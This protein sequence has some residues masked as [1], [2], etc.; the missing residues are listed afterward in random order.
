MQE[1]LKNYEVRKNNKEKTNFINY[2]YE[3][4]N[5]SG[6]KKEDIKI[7][8]RWKGVLKTRNIII[9][10]P[11]TAE[12]IVGA[13]YD[14]PA[15]SPLPNF[16]FPTNPIMFALSQLLVCAIIFLVAWL[17]M[18]PF[19][20]YVEDPTA[21]IYAFQ[22]TMIAFLLQ[23]SIGF[24]N[25]HT[26]ND[27]TSGVITLIKILENIQKE[28]RNKIC[29]VFFDN[30][31][32]GLF[33]SSFFA[34]KHPETQNKVL[35]NFDCVGDGD[36]I[37]FLTKKKSREEFVTKQ[38]NAIYSE[39]APKYNINYMYQKMKPLMFPSDQANFDKGIG[40]CAVRKAFFGLYAGR[41]HTP[42]DTK[43]E[44]NNLNFLCD[45]IVKF[46]EKGE[47]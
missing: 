23:L 27:N 8:E 35:I 20:L 36:N 5:K 12:I 42:F 3:R 26:A 47:Q 13:H 46:C 17:V 9:G 1:I 34:K 30:E 10:N 31:E 24:R 6:Y 18:I 16:M 15:L 28:N 2:L 21:C 40:V 38:I 4:L 29:V 37:L 45:G 25:K 19:A 41:I 43:C 11:E 14:T 22:W 7:E 39:I 44:E 32:K 33:G